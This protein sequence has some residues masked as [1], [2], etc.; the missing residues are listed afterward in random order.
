[1]VLTVAVL[2]P[3][4]FSRRRLVGVRLGV[5]AVAA[6]VA[7]ALLPTAEDIATL[8]LAAISGGLALGLAWG[9]LRPAVADRLAPG[10]RV[11]GLRAVTAGPPLALAVAGAAVGFAALDVAAYAMAVLALIGLGA[12]V[13]FRGAEQAVD[14]ELIRSTV[15]DEPTIEPPLPLGQAV[16]RLLS[17]DA[18]GRAGGLSAVTGLLLLPLPL[19]LV[20]HLDDR[21]GA[22]GDLGALA[23][24]ICGA[25]AVL[26][27]ALGSSSTAHAYAAD[28]G[29]PAHR[30]GRILGTSA[31]LL[32][33]LALV[34]NEVAA[35][36]LAASALGMA[37]GAVAR[38]ELVLFATLSQRLRDL[39]SQVTTVYLA[40]G[41]L[42]GVAVL[43][44]IDRRFGT[45]WALGVGAV[46]LVAVVPGLRRMARTAAAEL[47]RTLEHAIGTEEIAARRR[48]GEAVPLLECNGIDFAYGQ[49]QVLFGV[50]FSVSEGEMV[51]LLG[52]NGA[53][54]STLLRVISGLGFPKAGSVRFDG[55]DV[56][57]AAP[58]DRV[59]AGITQVPGG[60]AVFGPMSVVENL[61]VYGYAL[62]TD[63]AAVDR[64][65]EQA[66]E[67]FPRL[68]ERRNQT[69]QTL[70]GGEQ[71]MLALSK[72]LILQPRL[73]LIDELS[74]GLAPK[75]VAQLLDMV[76]EINQCGTA[77]VLVEQSVNVALSLVEHAYYME[78]GEVRFDGKAADLLERPD[79]LRSVYLKGA[80]EGLGGGA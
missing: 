79:I 60:K 54:K 15:H 9:T 30:A 44:A 77:I 51:A 34:R 26:V 32:V 46:A 43:A 24:G 64:G 17:R 66:F 5:A 41:A 21:F 35:V 13:R 56:T 38:V 63:K 55:Q 70:S 61:R 52:T 27:L 62:G 57:Y 11:V 45:A 12:A 31:V 7:N 49:V 78:K 22:P 69:A 6:A 40:L 42:L 2:A 58:G 75:I 76:R 53:G 25:T 18:F 37:W 16:R 8:S 65:I 68:A 33:A 72:A 1:M 47:D 67:A 10:A 29:R 20:F 19:F 74:L 71:Q 4:L 50:D 80:A 59:R 14:E 23:L 73:L 48:S 28:P 36:V 39:A 3:V